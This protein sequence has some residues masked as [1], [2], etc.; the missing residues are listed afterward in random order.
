MLVPDL[1]TA[2]DATS[3]FA[4]VNPY[5]QLGDGSTGTVQAGLY[6]PDPANWATAV[7]L[8][9][10]TQTDTGITVVVANSPTG[11]PGYLATS[12]DAT[13]ADYKFTSSS[14][15]YNAGTSDN[16]ATVDYF[17]TS[18]PQG[19]ACDMGF[20]ELLVSGG[21]TLLAWLTGGLGEYSGGPYQ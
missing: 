6:P 9:T 3:V 10:T 20:F 21:Q 12:N 14:P 18:R 7:Q 4:I 13:A 1:A 16:A 17:G 2:V 15:C 5:V 11:N 19:S 8:P